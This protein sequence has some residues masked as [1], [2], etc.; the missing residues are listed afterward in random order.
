MCGDCSNSLGRLLSKQQ[1]RIRDIRHLHLWNTW[2]P[3]SSD[4]IGKSEQTVHWFLNVSAQTV[5]C[6]FHSEPMTLPSSERAR[7][8]DESV[9]FIHYPP[10]PHDI[11]AR[12][13][14]SHIH[15]YVPL[16]RR[17]NRESKKL[18]KMLDVIKALRKS[19]SVFFKSRFQSLK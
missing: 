8:F 1:I 5:I 16:S 14:Y 7:T 15:I 11:P 19:G 10:G 13:V 2:L 6:H 17:R 3:H 18:S 9:L 12:H 4:R